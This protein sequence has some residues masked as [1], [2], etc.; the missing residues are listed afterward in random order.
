MGFADY[1]FVVGWHADALREVVWDL[2]AG[3]GTDERWGA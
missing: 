3:Q 2:V 1:H